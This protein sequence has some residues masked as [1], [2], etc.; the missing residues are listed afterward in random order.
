MRVL[1]HTKNVPEFLLHDCHMGNLSLM[2]IFTVHVLK[3]L[4]N[5]CYKAT[6]SKD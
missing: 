5:I 2:L 6:Y 3:K 1:C 4:Y